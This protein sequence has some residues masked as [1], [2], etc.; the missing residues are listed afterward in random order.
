MVN[1]ER[2]SPKSDENNKR[3][4]RDILGFFAHFE[5]DGDNKKSWEFARKEIE[6]ILAAADY[7]S[8]DD[9][10]LTANVVKRITEILEAWQPDL[11]TEKQVEVDVYLSK[12]INS[13]TDEFVIK[14]KGSEKTDERSFRNSD[15]L[16]F[17]NGKKIV[18]TEKVIEL[19]DGTYTNEL[20]MDMLRSEPPKYS[21]NFRYLL[22]VILS[23]MASG[24]SKK[25]RRAAIGFLK[26][27]GN[28][29]INY[30]GVDEGM[31][32]ADANHCL[33]IA[34]KDDI[35]SCGADKP[36]GFTGLGYT[37][38]YISSNIGE[39]KDE[40]LL[41]IF[42]KNMKLGNLDKKKVDYDNLKEGAKADLGAA[43]EYIRS[44]FAGKPTT[45]IEALEG[46][47]YEILVNSIKIYKRIRN[48]YKENRSTF[49]QNPDKK[50]EFNA[51]LGLL[52]SNNVYI[53]EHNFNTIDEN[54]MSLS[55]AYNNRNDS[56]NAYLS[57]SNMGRTL[58][59]EIDGLYKEIYEAEFTEANGGK[60]LKDMVDEEYEKELKKTKKTKE[61]IVSKLNSKM[62][63]IS[64]AGLY[65]DL[66]KIIAE[67]YRLGTE[68]ARDAK[69]LEIRNK[70]IF[71]E[72]TDPDL[73]KSAKLYK[74]LVLDRL[75]METVYMKNE[76]NIIK[77]AEI[78]SSQDDELYLAA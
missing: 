1:S 11:P 74:E 63:N 73:Q 60:S 19:A 29:E 41:R 48:F 7:K 56:L 33:S 68:S 6:A 51:M 76:L 67:E 78:E 5:T 15:T 36:N 49:D 23:N 57:K 16:D 55:E 54:I 65:N 52:S 22:R 42:A 4:L 53:T 2:R 37:Q 72:Q 10:S 24:G 28:K 44:L 77:G 45:A 69:K 21:E 34:A 8:D 50:A 27:Y 17:I 47:D 75:G 20:S 13:A 61:D 38:T 25:E 26:D 31:R 3:G 43:V 71:K 12:F 70:L 39:I 64:E 46:K 62:I 40:K 9:G 14:V 30:Y 35:Y 18:L 58:G 32:E 59:H 66:K